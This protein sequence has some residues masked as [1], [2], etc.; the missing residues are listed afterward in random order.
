M[1][2]HVKVVRPRWQITSA[3]VRNTLF[4]YTGPCDLLDDC[5]HLWFNM[6][7]HNGD[8]PAPPAHRIQSTVSWR[9]TRLKIK[10]LS[11]LD[12][13]IWKYEAAP[14]S[15]SK[16]HSAGN[17]IRPKCCAIEAATWDAR[18]RQASHLLL[19]CAD[20][21]CRRYYNPR[22]YAGLGESIAG[23]ARCS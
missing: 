14:S 12:L 2:A 19:I 10:G 8:K 5:R 21:A 16:S 13:T 3:F 17:Y 9:R 11:S 4:R 6:S 20:A 15:G 22:K 18:W 7:K 1:H 23:P